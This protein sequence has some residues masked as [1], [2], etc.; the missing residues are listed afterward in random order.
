MTRTN[1]PSTSRILPHQRVRRRVRGLKIAILVFF[2]CVAARLVYIQVIRAEA[3]R[4]RARQQYESRVGLPAA[5]GSILDR[6]GKV[7]VSNM[8]YASYA[9][10]PLIARGERDEIASRFAQVFDKPRETYMGQMRDVSRRFV[11]LERAVKPSLSARIP[12]S[13]MRGLILREEP[14]RLY[15]YERAAG[16]LLGVIGVDNRGLSGLEQQYDRY[17]KGRDGEVTLQRDALRRARPSVDYPRIEPIDGQNLVL[18]IDADIQSVVEEE[19]EQGM[20][21]AQAESGVAIIVEPASGEILAMATYPSVSLNST[22]D[23]DLAALRNRV[24]TDAF[25]PGSIFKLVTISSVLEN[26]AA[27]LD[28]VFNAENGVYRV[29]TGNSRYRDITDTHKFTVLTFQ[30]AV[31]HS[32]NIVM[33][34]VA[35]RIGQE[36]M[37]RMARAYGFGAPTGIELPAEADGSLKKPSEW[38]GTTLQSMAYGYGRLIEETE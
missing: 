21:R 13:E 14:K 15:H 33:A 7:L 12:A 10:D 29:P 3:Y 16:Q 9:V 30:K 8:M 5:R 11:W 38:S 18:T 6:N 26:K 17:L 34:K 2:L 32:S 31:E 35:L 23:L 25:E 28:E 20:N 37:F 1:E 36:K 24:I 4:T 27:R 22:A 19:L